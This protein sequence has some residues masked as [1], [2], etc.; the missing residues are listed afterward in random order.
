MVFLDDHQK[1]DTDIYT[2]TAPY[3]ITGSW[4]PTD[5]KSV[6][7]LSVLVCVLP[8]MVRKVI[9]MSKFVAQ[10]KAEM[11]DTAFPRMPVGKIALKTTWTTGVRGLHRQK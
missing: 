4:W 3:N 2:L 7:N 10:L 9:D 6:N 8:V 11:T 1:L 5:L